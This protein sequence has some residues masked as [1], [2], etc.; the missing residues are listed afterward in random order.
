MTPH[1]TIG[2]PG[3]RKLAPGRAGRKDAADALRGGCPIVR[4]IRG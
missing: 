1:L 2:W 3:C 4:L